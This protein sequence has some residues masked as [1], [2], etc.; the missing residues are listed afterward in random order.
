MNSS[1]LALLPGGVSSRAVTLSEREPSST[2]F[3]GPKPNW[4]G[5]SEAPH[6]TLMGWA[7]RASEQTASGLDDAILTVSEARDL[8][9]VE[10]ALVLI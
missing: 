10:R 3:R 1:A 7:L 6:L 9:E 8:C 5:V 4:Q 2:C